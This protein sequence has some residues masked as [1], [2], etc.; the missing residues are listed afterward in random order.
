MHQ[1]LVLH[2]PAAMR[3][4]DERRARGAGARKAE[5]VQAREARERRLSFMVS[6]LWGGVS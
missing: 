1:P 3:T 5:A 6:G 4:A 2:L